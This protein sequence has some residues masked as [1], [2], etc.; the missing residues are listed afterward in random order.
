MT[1]NIPGGTLSL[2]TGMSLLSLVEILYWIIRS[3]ETL[4]HYA[5]QQ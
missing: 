4:M 2:F 5:A 1:P 3:F